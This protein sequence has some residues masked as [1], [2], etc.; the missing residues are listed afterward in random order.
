M[1]KLDDVNLFYSEQLMDVGVFDADGSGLLSYSAGDSTK[2]VVLKKRRLCLPT[3]AILTAGDWETRI[4][5]IPLSEQANC[6]PSEVLNAFKDY[7]RHALA[8]R[9]SK[10]LML[11]M[12]LAVNSDAKSISPKSMSL[13]TT[14]ADADA[15]TMDALKDILTATGT[16]PEKR[17]ISILLKS[18]ATSDYLRSCIVTF[19]IMADA[20]DPDQSTF[21]GVKMPRKTKD[22][23]LLVALL[24]YVF[25]TKGGKEEYT[26]G[27]NDPTA[28]FYH[29]LLQSF[30]KM[31]THF[32]SIVDLHKGDIPGLEDLRFRLKWVDTL[33]TFPSFAASHSAIAPPTPGNRGELLD[34]ETEADLSVFNDVKD[35]LLDNAPAPK[36]DPNWDPNRPFDPEDDGRRS[37]RRDRDRDDDYDRSYRRSRRD[38]DDRDERRSRRD[39]DIDD[40]RRDRDDRDSGGRDWN[41]YMRGIRR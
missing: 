18:N 38:R 15:K 4:A 6:G 9:Y 31:A 7:I 1:S 10:V 21:F 25:G 30:E 20:N 41:D 32:N 16:K 35:D 2:P 3:H 27:S 37:R 5:F 14:L 23:R 39:Y 11:L 28:P 22:K 8:E 33:R 34:G 12:N 36:V 26:F 29:S 13:L 24:E 19:P 17:I 40:R